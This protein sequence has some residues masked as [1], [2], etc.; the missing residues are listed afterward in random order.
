[1]ASRSTLLS[2]SLLAM[3]CLPEE[4]L[5]TQ[6]DEVLPAEGITSMDIVA[7]AGDLR[8]E[9]LEGLEEIR[10]EVR[11]FTQLGACE[12]DEEVLDELDYELYATTEG[13]ARLWVDVDDDWMAYWADV[14]VQIPAA[15]DLQVRDGSGDLEISDVASLVLDDELGDAS[16]ERIAGEVEIEDG[17]GDLRIAHIGGAL[18]LNDENGDTNILDV[19]GPT[20]IADGTGDLWIEEVYAHLRIEDGSGDMALRFIDGDVDIDDGGGD[21]EVRDVSGTVRIHDESGDIHAEDVGDLEVIEDGS[22]DVDW[23]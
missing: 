10:V 22:G 14:V 11:I 21:I 3:G 2:L 13:E 7:G 8:V 23:D 12:Q 9:G 20:Q 6:F 19:A 5:V 15:L 1:M 16:I 18:T 4:R 17:S